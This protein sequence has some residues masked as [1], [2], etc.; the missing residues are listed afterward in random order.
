[1]WALRPKLFIQRCMLRNIIASKLREEG[2]E[3]HAMLWLF[4]YTYLLRVPSE[5]FL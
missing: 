4:A 3:K 1:M 2:G 5:V